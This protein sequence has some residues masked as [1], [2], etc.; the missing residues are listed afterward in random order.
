MTDTPLLERLRGLIER[1]EKRA[2]E[3]EQCA[4]NNEVVAA[5]FEPQMRMFDAREGH[6][7]YAVRMAIDHRQSGKRDRQYAAD[8]REAIAALRALSQEQQSNG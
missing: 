1:L 2:A 6:N 3:D 7:I 8:L 5:L 4:V